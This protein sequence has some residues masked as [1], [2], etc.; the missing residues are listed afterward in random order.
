MM[1]EVVLEVCKGLLIDVIEPIIYEKVQQKIEERQIKKML[2]EFSNRLNENTLQERIRE[3][4]NL[5]YKEIRKKI[6]EGDLNILDEIKSIAYNWIISEDEDLQEHQ[7]QLSEAFVKMILCYIK[8]EDIG[9][10]NDLCNS[11]DIK[12]IKQEID[13]LRKQIKQKEV[14]DFLKQKGKISLHINNVSRIEDRQE[15]INEIDQ[16]YKNG[17]RIVFLYGPPGIGKT[18]LAK[19]Y[20]NKSNFENVFF[21]NYKNNFKKTLEELL[22]KKNE[23]DVED[24]IKY[25]RDLSEKE[26]K[27]TLVII[28]NFNDDYGSENQIY[29]EELKSDLFK[30]LFDTGVFL[31]ITTR[32]N[33]KKNHQEVGPLRD[34]RNLFLS[35]CESECIDENDKRID[36]LIKIVNGNTLLVIL[37]A[38]I[39][40]ESNNKNELLQKLRDGRMK[41]DPHIIPN[42]TSNDYSVEG[43]TF[44]DQLTEI[45]HY[46][47]ILKSEE[48]KKWMG[49]AALLPSEGMEKKEF[50]SIMKELDQNEMQDL[51]NRQWISQNRERI[52]VHAGIREV[53]RRNQDIVMYKNCQLYCESISKKIDMDIERNFYNRVSYCSYAQEIYNVFLHERNEDLL[54]M[55]YNLTDIYDNLKEKDLAR[56]IGETIIENQGDVEFE[57]VKTARVLSGIAYSMIQEAKRVKDLDR[58][59]KMLRRAEDILRKISRENRDVY[60]EEIR[61]KVFSNQAAL[62]QKTAGILERNSTKK[63]RESFKLHDKILT[64]RL[65]VKDKWENMINERKNID[66]RSE[67]ALSYKNVATEQYHLEKYEDAIQNHKK[68]IEIYRDIGDKSKEAVLE[69]LMIG[70]VIALYKKD[71]EFRKEILEEVLGYYPKIIEVFFVNKQRKFLEKSLE[72]FLELE[73][74]INIDKNGVKFVKSVS[75][76]KKQIK[77]ILEREYNFENLN[78]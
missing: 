11:L 33:V 37:L 26:K 67:I 15:D 17:Q 60:Y 63:Y 1:E 41:D 55:Y 68:G 10:Y 29:Y 43:K 16:K 23:E 3:N 75:E 59:G 51:I 18:T 53:T 46:G 69:Y 12:E 54:W 49:S 74:I 40:E 61:G 76:R 66:L 36:E 20:A 8:K 39:W 22:D 70:C 56:E 6:K 7:G 27:K 50:L 45:L 47:P 64:Y 5:I 77:T 52:F 38:Y 13:D 62:L 32:I 57:D 71:L 4:L 19:I 65:K 58:P 72:M 31:L 14:T 2:L 35:C 73:K 9:F 21:L 44:Y 24:I 78:C 34:V 25:F 42:E 28:D 30:K 48:K